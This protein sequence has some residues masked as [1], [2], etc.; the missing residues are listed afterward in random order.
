[1]LV[2]RTDF[3][4]PR[5]LRTQQE[6]LPENTENEAGGDDDPHGNATDQEGK[7]SARAEGRLCVW[8]GSN[9]LYVSGMFIRHSEGHSAWT[10]FLHYILQD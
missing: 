10:E 2:Q 1:M 7:G 4:S 3:L 5:D 9:L 6:Q 8:I